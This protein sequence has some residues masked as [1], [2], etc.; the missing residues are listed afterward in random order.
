MVLHYRFLFKRLISVSYTI[1]SGIASNATESDWDSG[2]LRALIRDQQA[3][4]R[5]HCARMEIKK[6][7]FND[8]KEE[9]RRLKSIVRRKDR[10]IEQLTSKLLAYKGQLHVWRPTRNPLENEADSWLGL[11]S[12]EP[13]T[14]ISQCSTP[15]GSVTTEVLDTS[16]ESSPNMAASKKGRP[17]LQSDPSSPPR[18]IS[19]PSTSTTRL[20][21]EPSGLYE[22]PTTPEESNSK[23]IQEELPAQVFCGETCNSD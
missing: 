11:S 17:R 12:S 21:L 4:M 15:S 2:K 23:D 6:R 7:R 14:P 1:I 22:M 3:T 9:N 18:P 20:V 10:D 16:R 8:L 5:S 19:P 13:G